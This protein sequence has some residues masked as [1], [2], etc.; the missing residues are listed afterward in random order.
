MLEE[1]LNISNTNVFMFICQLLTSNPC[2]IKPLLITNPLTTLIKLVQ[3][4][5][6]W[7]ANFEMS[8]ST[9]KYLSDLNLSYGS[10]KY[11]LT[12]N[13]SWC[14]RSPVVSLDFPFFISSNHTFQVLYQGN[15]NTTGITLI[16][17]ELCE[18]NDDYIISPC[19]KGKAINIRFE[20][21]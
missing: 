13:L 18:V 3:T 11:S 5:P 16:T 14:I 7:Q 4:K 9:G 17:I 21:I 20:E 15:A 12:W 2:H 19:E 10:G 6:H 8:L 1:A